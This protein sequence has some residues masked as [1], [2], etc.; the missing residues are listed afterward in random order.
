[1]PV[2]YC[3][4]RTFSCYLNTEFGLNL[5]KKWFDLD[6][7]GLEAIV[8]RYSRGKRKGQLKGQIVWEKTVVGGWST[9]HG[10]VTRP[11]DIHSRNIC[12]AWTGEV[13]HRYT[14]PL[15]EA[16][17]A[18]IEAIKAER[19]QALVTARQTVEGLRGS[20]VTPEFEKLDQIHK[21]LLTKI[22]AEREAVLAELEELNKA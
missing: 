4:I 12:D 10:G 14:P 19:A 2:Q 5:A 6:E 8:G 15:T 9:R 16:D 3:K 18:A 1:M 17:K 7:A 22:L 11:G 13:L 21:D 20:M